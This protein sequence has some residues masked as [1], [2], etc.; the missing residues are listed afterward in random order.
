MQ[1]KALIPALLAIVF[2][3]RDAHAQ[4]Q[5]SANEWIL[6]FGHLH[7]LVLH[8]PIGFLVL[9]FTF[10]FLSGIKKFETLGPA[11]EFTLLLGMLSAVLA[12][13]LGYFLSLDGGY[14]GALL[15]IH[16][17]LGVS[18]AVF[19]VALYI[20]KRR[21]ASPRLIKGM[22]VVLMILMTGTGHYGGMLTHG[23]DYLTASLP[24]SVKNL[25]GVAVE[26]QTGPLAIKNVEEAVV[27]DDLVKPIL[28]SKCVSCHNDNKMKGELNLENKE[29]I[30]QGGENGDIFGNGDAE[31]SELI[32]LIRLPM[33]E[34]RHMPPSGKTQLEEEEM[35][36]LEWWVVQGHD[37]ENKV[38]Q[39]PKD[40]D[41]EVI[42]K[43]IE[44]RANKVI[45]P[46]MTMDIA[47]ASDEDINEISG[48]GVYV[49]RVSADTPYLLARL[50]HCNSDLKQL[51]GG[52]SQQLIWLNMATSNCQNETLKDLPEFPHLTRLHLQNTRVNDEVMDYLAG[53][54]YLEYL[55]LYGTQVS[56]QGILK[57]IKLKYLKNLYLWKTKVTEEGVAALQAQSPELNINYGLEQPVN[58]P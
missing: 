38:A 26:G 14:G 9:A 42:L 34:E 36:L 16:Q 55:N 3:V 30:L 43:T 47:E 22:M 24:S 23:E 18:L 32:K 39:L 6:F 19:S 1:K 10:E 12:A 41:I 51:L 56:D 5:E 31:E 7:P 25:L 28:D 27:F 45:N 53:L 20:L 21:E 29:A 48:N 40:E 13:L 58:L 37:F 11:T 8:L 46:V 49:T 17:W 50:D 57:L 54:E 44:S 35:A 4:G 15:S 2:F 33:E 52:V